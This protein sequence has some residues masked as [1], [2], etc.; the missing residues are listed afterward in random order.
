MSHAF[1]LPAQTALAAALLALLA[2]GASITAAWADPGDVVIERQIGPRIAYRGIPIPENPIST[3]VEAFPTKPFNQAMASVRNAS[4]AEL[5]VRSSVGITGGDIS[6]AL[7][8]GLSAN[9]N[10]G[11]GSPPNSGLTAGSA[12]GG[13][14]ANTVMGATGSLGAGIPSTINQALKS[15]PG[16]VGGAK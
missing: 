10:M 5:L 1:L 12:I 8:D 6:R 16:M 4:D 14:L 13:S 2:G 7:T 3:R 9:G 11:V 15:L